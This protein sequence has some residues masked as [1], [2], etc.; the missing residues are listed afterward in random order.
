M[1][2]SNFNKFAEYEKLEIP[3]GK[4]VIFKVEG[5]KK[6]PDPQNRGRWIFPRVSIRATDFIVDS[7]GKTQHIAYISREKADGEAE[8][9]EVTFAPEAR[10]VIKV[11]SGVAKDEALYKYLMLTDQNGSKKNRDTTKPVRFT[12]YDPVG[13]AEAKRAARRLRNSAINKAIAI[14]DET[15][16]SILEVKNISIGVGFRNAI[17][18]F[19]ENNPEE[20]FRLCEQFDEEEDVLQLIKD[21]ISAGLIEFDSKEK[22]AS[23][24]KGDESE[25]IYT[26]EGKR[27]NEDF[28]DY[29]KVNNQDAIDFL[30]ENV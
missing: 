19:A 16:K 15:A 26:W 24:K 29:L 25:V 8:F 6:D 2:A 30:S 7:N 14:S 5:I 13:E 21:G 11:R 10:G 17:E 23:L 3:K 27:K 20:F 22:T 4:T 9:G 1:K 18:S 12:I 28:A